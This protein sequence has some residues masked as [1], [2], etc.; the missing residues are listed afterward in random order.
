MNKALGYYTCNG[1]EFE[2]KIL[3]CLYATEV[4]QP[5]QWVFNDDIFNA[6]NWT[7]EPSE[8]LDELYDRRA[9]ALRERYDYIILNYS[10]GSDSHNILTSFYRQGLLLDEV[11]TNWTIDATKNFTIADPQLTSSWNHNAEYELHTRQRLQ[12]ISDN[13]PDTK[14][15]FF[16]ASTDILNYF[17]TARDESW[18]LNH[19]DHI[20]PAVVQRFN[21]LRLKGVHTRLDHY[22]N[23]AVV[24]GV[25]KPR[26][27][28]NQNKECYVFFMDNLANITP[29]AQHLDDYTNT[30]V[31]YFY[32]S[33]NCCDLLVKQAHSIMKY[34]SQNK[35][36]ISLFYDKP[37]DRTSQEVLLK[38]ILYA[39]SW[40]SSWFQVNKPIADWDCELDLWFSYQFK[41]TDIVRNW[42]AGLNF[43]NNNVDEIFFNNKTRG[44]I[45]YDSPR[46]FVGNL[47]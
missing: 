7:R 35:Q 2:S 24:V 37:L 23:V 32:W 18:V 45:L 15:T 17:K 31:E 11:V 16:D 19:K 38:R 13:M 34:L 4:K 21:Y 10:G 40:D 5:I 44:L 28:I 41:N 30:T 33:P 25:D 9:R 1:R 12:W 39:T 14:I 36:Y 26:F 6:T 27:V 47:T 43:L 3:A 46:W 42:N 20:N 22:Q 8:S 29:V